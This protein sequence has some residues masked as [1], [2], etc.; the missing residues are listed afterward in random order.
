MKATAEF[1]GTFQPSVASPPVAFFLCANPYQ[2]GEEMLTQLT[3]QV[4]LGLLGV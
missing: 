2:A 3:M 1:A 4:R